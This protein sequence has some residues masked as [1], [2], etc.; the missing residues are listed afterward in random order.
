GQAAEGSQCLR[1][2]ASA[3]TTTITAGLW[4]PFATATPSANQRFT[5]SFSYLPVLNTSNTVLTVRLSGDQTAA[6]PTLPPAP[7]TPP[8]PPV[9]V[10][11][12]YSKLANTTASLNDLRAYHVLHAVQ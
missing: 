7:P 2:V 3:A 5:L 4:Q 9:S 10:S 6:R 12:V 1:L 11:P 8:V